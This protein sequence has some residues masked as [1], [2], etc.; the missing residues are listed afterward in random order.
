MKTKVE[1]LTLVNTLRK[2]REKHEAIYKRAR[3]GFR[4]KAK[5]ALEA[6][7]G[8]LL[9]D[10]W[11]GDLYFN[12]SKPVSNL[13]DYD[14]ALEMCQMSTDEVIELNEED[15]A[16]FVLDRWDWKEHFVST[17]SAYTPVDDD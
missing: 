8:A 16:H 15:F 12:L 6:R 11:D 14:L 17:N 5:A 7:L 2:N 3:E 10:K 13:K 9:S 4:S 1:K